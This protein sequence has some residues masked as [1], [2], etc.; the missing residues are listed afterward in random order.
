MTGRL[1][2]NAVFIY[3]SNVVF[4]NKLESVNSCISAAKARD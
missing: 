4:Q 3:A 1:E 2:K